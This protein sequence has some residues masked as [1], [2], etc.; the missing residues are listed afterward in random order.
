MTK[1]H[2]IYEREGKSGQVTYYIRYQVAGRDVK[3]K[4][5]RK[6]QGCTRELAKQA[7]KARQGDVTRGRFN[8]AQALK[9]VPFSTLLRRFDTYAQDAWRGY[10]QN[11]YFLHALG[12]YFG[13][14]PLAS[15]STWDIE[16]WKADLRK[17]L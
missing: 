15:L 5:G 9:P 1:A 13:D 6:S 7:L 10:E 17:S 11:K 4:V 2:G 3:E 14:K 12:R 8:I 16:K